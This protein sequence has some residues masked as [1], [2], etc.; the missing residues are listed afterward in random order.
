M[1]TRDS[2]PLVGA[3]V[4]LKPMVSAKSRLGTLPEPLRRRIAWTMSVDTLRALSAGVDQV[5][6][7]SDEPALQSRLSRVGIEVTVVSEPV[8]V[9]LNGALLVGAKL[10]AE[11]GCD[12]V[13]ACVGDLPAL[14]AT[15][16][17]A[18]VTASR[19]HSRCFVADAA[20]VGTTMLLARGTA[21]DP[22]FEGRS[23]AAHRASGAVGLGADSLGG[24]LADARHD[25]DTDVDLRAA[26]VLGLGRA[27]AALVDQA[28]GSLGGYDS[29]TVAERH[30]PDGQ[31]A[32]ITSG[33]YR[34]ALP[35][36]A[37]QDGLLRV[38]TG[39]RLHAVTA[40]NQVLAAW[41]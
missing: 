18:V 16:V 2:P 4:G 12:S 15:S 8:L 23:A 28:T 40:Q 3:V 17:R 11:A 33:G 35:A 37:L 6:V 7:V 14:Q 9:G 26:V 25:V 10:L 38:H 30:R 21:L 19:S 1:D 39:Q 31:R 20:G 27:T 24:P 36:D 41:I 32:A 29:V 13:L 34:V 22:H 5:L